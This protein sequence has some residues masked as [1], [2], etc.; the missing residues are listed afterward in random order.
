MD[1]LQAAATGVCPGAAYLFFVQSSENGCLTKPEGCGKNARSEFIITIVNR[2]DQS[3]LDRV[4]FSVRNSWLP[5]NT[6][7]AAR[8]Q[9]AFE[10]LALA[11]TGGKAG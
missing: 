6:D 3:L 10:Q 11:L 2:G 9:S 5:W 4:K 7:S 8:L 1:Y